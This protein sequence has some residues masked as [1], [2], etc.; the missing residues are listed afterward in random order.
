M[1]VWLDSAEH[2]QRPQ[3]QSTTNDNGSLVFDVTDWRLAGYEFG[4]RAAQEATAARMS[5]LKRPPVNVVWKLKDG[6]SS[7]VVLVT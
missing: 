4:P 6:G 2:D 5:R 7:D 3:G 1:I